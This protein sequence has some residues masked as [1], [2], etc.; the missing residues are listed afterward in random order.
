LSFVVDVEFESRALARQGLVVRRL[1]R[2]VLRLP[3]HANKAAGKMRHQHGI[4]RYRFDRII[5][6]A[7]AG[8]QV[9]PAVAV[10]I[11]YA[12]FVIP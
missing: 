6:L 5:M 4:S 8:S 9:S 11:R 3:A 12:P 10:R 7:G 1:E 2:R